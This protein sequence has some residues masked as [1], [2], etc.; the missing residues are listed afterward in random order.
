[1]FAG[2]VAHGGNLLLNVGPTGDGTIPF[3]QAQRLLAL[4]WWLR[5]NGPAIYGTRPWE[6]A[7]GRTGEGHE[8]RFTSSPAD[9]AV[10]AIVLDTPTTAEVELLD[11]EVPSGGTVDLLGHDRPLEH[12]SSGSGTVVRLPDLPASAPALTLRI[13]TA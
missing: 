2:I 6:R 4:G 5:T 8:V 11:V 10:H 13:R 9:G 7:E 3:L 1:M 12:R